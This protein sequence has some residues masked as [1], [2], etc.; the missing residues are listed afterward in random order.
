MINK[1]KSISLKDKSREI[2]GILTMVVGLFVLL[3]LISHEP[4]EE[5]SIMP[6]VHFY[7]WMGYVGIFISYVLFKMFIGWGS[8]II[9]VLISI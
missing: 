4:T 9:A 5:L 6:G 7:N 2:L 1:N 3:S 8:L